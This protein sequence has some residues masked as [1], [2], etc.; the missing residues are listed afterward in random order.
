[1]YGAGEWRNRRELLR[2][3]WQMEP[4][5]PRRSIGT[6]LM[7][8]AGRNSKSKASSEPELKRS[9]PPPHY[10][11][12]IKNES[13]PASLEPRK[14]YRVIADPDAARHGLIRVVDESAVDYL[15]PQDFFVAISLPKAAEAA[16]S[17]M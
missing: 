8:S 12:C 5:A 2:Y 13:Y 11:L 1:M 7:A 16:F 10:A 4:Y 3:G 17:E 15:Y 9:E 14:V 6:K